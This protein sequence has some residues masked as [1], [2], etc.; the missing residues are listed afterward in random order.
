MAGHNKWS[1]VKRLKG[2]LDAKRGTLFS[3]FSRKITVAAKMGGG[4]LDTNFRLRGAVQV[5]RA[6]KMP[7]DTMVSAVKKGTREL[8][9][10]E[11]LY[12][13]ETTVK[14]TDEATSSQVWKL[15]DA[16]DECDDV[17]G[18]H[19]NFDI[20]DELLVQLSA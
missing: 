6:Q 4:D 16:F 13:P 3:R 5:V 12:L 8:E 14:V 1:K 15:C 9:S 7:S 19:A 20:S 10:L 17:Q 11:L 2:A 18:V